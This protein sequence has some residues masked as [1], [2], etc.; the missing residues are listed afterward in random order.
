MTDVLQRPDTHRGDTRA[1][2]PQA[3]FVLPRMASLCC[4]HGVGC[5]C[6]GACQ[7]PGMTP[8][9]SPDPAHFSGT[10]AWGR[11]KEGLLTGWR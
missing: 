1:T 10:R 8:R 6:P 3:A 5:G 11:W 7:A 9:P 2:L 4:G